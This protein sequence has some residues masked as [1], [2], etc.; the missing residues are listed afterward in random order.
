ME[1][2]QTVRELL[3][4]NDWMA[5][6]DLKDTYFTNNRTTPEVSKV[7]LGTEE[8]PAHSPTIW[9][10]HSPKGLYKGTQTSNDLS[11]AERGKVHDYLNDLLLLNQAKKALS[12]DIALCV[13]LLESLGF[14]VKYNKSDLTATQETTF[15]GF[16]I[17][18][19]SRE[20]RLPADK[21]R[22]LVADARQLLRRDKVSAKDLTHT[23][24]MMSTAIL[25]VYPVPL[26]YRCLQTL[27]HKA[28]KLGGYNHIRQSLSIL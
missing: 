14:L 18:S 6:I 24:G 17:N 1:G 25:A 21:L 11:Q 7:L 3:R 8:L 12:E 2:I 4:V 27:K 5:R 16:V 28:L 10:F 15:L 13:N 9:A 22:Q 20:L 19:R 26:H 23:C